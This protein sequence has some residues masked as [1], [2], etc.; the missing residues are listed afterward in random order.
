MPESTPDVLPIVPTAALLL[1]HVPP[2]DVLV[3]VTLVAGHSVVEPPIV[4]GRGLTVM[5]R[6]RKQPLVGWVYVMV[7][8]PALLPVIKPVAEPIDALVA[9]LLVHVPPVGVLV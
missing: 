7:A 4:A 5:L 6:A 9:L 1:L 3:S 2:D 8:V